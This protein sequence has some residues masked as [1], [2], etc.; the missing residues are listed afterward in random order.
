[1][2]PE[3]A[4][5]APRKPAARAWYQLDNAAKIYPAI[6]NARW[7]SNFRMSVTLKEPVDPALLQ[8]ALDR[9]A[10]RFPNFRLRLRRG[11]FWYYLEENKKRAKVEPD[12]RFPCEKLGARQGDY[13][14]FRV[15]YYGARIA[16]EVFHAVCDG[17]GLLYFL[18][19][20]AAQY[21]MLAHPVSIPACCGVLDCGE[22]SPPE[23]MEDAF[24]RYA[25]YR[26]YKSRREAKA[27]HYD[28]T[29]EPIN[30]MHIVT[31]RIPLENL[32]QKAHEYRASLTE[33]LVAVLI[34]ALAE[35]QKRSTSHVER[36]VKVSVPVSMRRF[37][38]SKTL[39]NFSLFVNPGIEPKYGEYSFE[40]ILDEVHHFMRS[41]VKEKYLNAIMCKNLSNEQNL[42]MRVV[43]LFLKDIC[44]A[45]AFRF[46]GESRFSSTLSNVGEVE[47][48]DE[49]R[50]FIERFD[51]LLG[52]SLYHNGCVTAVSFNGTLSVTFTRGIR[53]A[54][55]ERN[56]FTALVKMGI[57]V[58][59][60]SNQA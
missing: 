26:A 57:P 9:T 19:T 32:L 45:L 16:V 54:E 24:K 31:G 14:L 43:P 20:L 41:N 21:L 8:C 58:K 40:E 36:P 38:P 2:G 6:N 59:V 25:T 29:P 48:P 42:F 15:R 7:S 52:R 13:Q 3:K 22:A 23:E 46:Y 44:L 33:F 1:M 47:V 4:I 50:P 37:Y 49:M 5:Q 17:T 35:C 11:L 60:E 53:E 18:K 30:V 10:A 27:Y 12:V 39:R 28:G 34:G 55:I 51:F 56:F